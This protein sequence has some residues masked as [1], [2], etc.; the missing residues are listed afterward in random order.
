MAQYSY[1]G[2]FRL[3]VTNAM[4]DQLIGLL[5]ELEPAPLSE[6]AVATVERRG[7]IYQLFEDDQLVYVGKSAKNLQGRLTKHRLKIAGRVND[8]IDHMTFR[9]AYVDEDLDAVAP[10]KLLIAE[11]RAL[12]QAEWNS[13]GFGNNDPGKQRDTS[14]VKGNHFDRLHPI[15]LDVSVALPSPQH[16][17][18]LLAVMD[19]LKRALPYTFRF[20][21]NSSARAALS[22]IDVTGALPPTMTRT[23]RE[24]FEWLM[25]LLPEGWVIVA[26]PGYVIAYANFEPATIPS[27]T[28]DWAFR[29]HRVVAL[30]HEPEYEESAEEIAEVPE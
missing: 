3:S 4:R 27:R 6:A 25:P 18:T 8:L 5:D 10:E 13:N 9:C 17:T 20:D 23:A 11:F 12:G 19:A 28:M 16:P 24:W 2:N 1:I 7:G 15:N 14:A 30:E 29:E 22:K 21:G 26:L